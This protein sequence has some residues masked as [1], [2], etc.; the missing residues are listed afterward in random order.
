MGVILKIR[1]IPTPTAMK[2]VYIILLFTTF[3]YVK[4][5]L[6]VDSFKATIKNPQKPVVKVKEVKVKL[7]VEIGETPKD[8]TLRLKNIDTVLDLFLEAQNTQGFYYEADLYTY[9]TEIVSV[10]DK[11]A[12][13]GKKWAVL[14]DGSDITHNIASEYLIDKAV[15]TLKE[16]ASD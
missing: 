16:V 14:L 13:A 11:G 7:V 6:D 1:K 4:S 2:V 10:F 15:Y 3:F 12:D 5:V 9:G 8:Y